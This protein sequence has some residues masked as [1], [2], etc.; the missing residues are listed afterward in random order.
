MR[1]WEMDEKRGIGGDGRWERE[2]RRREREE[3]K[4]DVTG[5][6]NGN[7]GNFS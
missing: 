7:P 2:E 3:E 1:G 5:T 6:E 4:K